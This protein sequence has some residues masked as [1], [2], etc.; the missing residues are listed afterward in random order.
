M[1]TQHKHTVF[2]RHAHTNRIMQGKMAV[3]HPAWVGAEPISLTDVWGPYAHCCT[4]IPPVPSSTARQMHSDPDQLAC[5]PNIMYSISTAAAPAAPLRG[6]AWAPHSR[7]VK[8]ARQSW[9]PHR[10]SQ[11][12]PCALHH[13][14]RGTVSPCLFSVASGAPTY[15][16]PQRQRQHKFTR[17]RC[18]AHSTGS[19]LFVP[20]PTARLA[21][22][23]GLGCCCCWWRRRR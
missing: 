1:S 23:R 15:S 22:G 20:T 17:S 16:R 8:P 14:D 5:H 3:Y 4:Q 18:Q 21:L 2:L 7:R 9:A 11:T 19:V 12:P 6:R 10:C 13:M